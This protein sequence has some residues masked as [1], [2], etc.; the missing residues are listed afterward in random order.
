ML[1]VS[2]SQ[3]GDTDVSA[4][5]LV[6]GRFEQEESRACTVRIYRVLQTPPAARAASG[7]PTQLGARS[8]AHQHP[9]AK[10]TSVLQAK[11]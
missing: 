1:A 11:T 8:S 9:V 4:N 5:P 7:A 2:L 6:A 3:I 10:A